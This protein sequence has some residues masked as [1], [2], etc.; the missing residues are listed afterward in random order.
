MSGDRFLDMRSISSVLLLRCSVVCLLLAEVWLHMLREPPYQ[1][2]LWDQQMMGWA[3]KITTGLEWR[4]FLMNPL[5]SQLITV[6]TRTMIGLLML[7]LVSA[8]LISKKRPWARYGLYLA[9]VILSFQSF[10]SFLN[11]GYQLPML[12]EHAL[13]IAA[14]WFLA[15]A[16][17]KGVTIPL[18]RTMLVAIGLTFSS[19]GLYAMGLGVPVPGHFIDMVMESI[20][21]SQSFATTLLLIAGIL[22]QVMVAGLFFLATREISLLYGVFWGFVT[23]LA[24]ITSY[25]RMDV[26]FGMS[27][28]AYFPEFL[29]RAPH[30]VIPLVLWRLVK[31]ELNPAS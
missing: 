17:L 14:P 27:L 19:H 1:A 26:L 23:A 20:G 2:F 30:F 24:R 5:A 31:R 4:D 16:A 21:V 18:K 28:L 29:V 11:V 12:L 10:C 8:L 9:S 3:V 22:D 15:V 25:V 6:V 7:G 13:R